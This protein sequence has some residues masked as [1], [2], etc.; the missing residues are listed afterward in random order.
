MRLLVALALLSNPSS[1]FFLCFFMTNLYIFQADFK[2]V[3]LSY[4]YS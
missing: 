3:V 2:P 4:Q 1:F